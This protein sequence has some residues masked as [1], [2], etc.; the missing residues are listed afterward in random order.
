[1]RL[2]ARWNSTLAAKRAQIGLALLDGRGMIRSFRVN[3]CRI[4]SRQSPLV[5]GRDTANCKTGDQGSGWVCIVG[6]VT[7]RN[8]TDTNAADCRRGHR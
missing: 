2:V 4:Q 1:M 3:D 8:A 6:G 7:R 5:A